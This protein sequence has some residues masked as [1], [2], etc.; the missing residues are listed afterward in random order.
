MMIALTEVN[1]S[2]TFHRPTTHNNLTRVSRKSSDFEHSSINKPKLSKE[3]IDKIVERL[4]KYDET[5][6]PPGSNRA[7][8]YLGFG[9]YEYPHRKCMI[10][11]GKTLD[12]TEIDNLIERLKN[13]KFPKISETITYS[14]NLKCDTIKLQ[15][16]IAHLTADNQTKLPVESTLARIDLGFNRYDFGCSSASQARPIMKK[17]NKQELFNVTERLSKYDINKYPPESKGHMKK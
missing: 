12:K 16:I 17:L 5:T 1:S 8:M 4:T 9:R 14:N 15:E 7:K 13:E 2:S 11:Q 10:N 6:G 3:E